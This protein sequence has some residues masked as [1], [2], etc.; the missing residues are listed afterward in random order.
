M[1]YLKIFTAILM[2][3]T[4][5]LGYCNKIKLTK[6]FSLL[7]GAIYIFLAI[8]TKDY[9]NLCWSS[10][11]LVGYLKLQFPYIYEDKWISVEDELPL[12][13]EDVLV[14][15]DYRKWG[16]DLKIHQARTHL[17]KEG[18]PQKYGG[19]NSLTGSGY[20]TGIYFSLPSIVAPEI[21]TH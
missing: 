18:F 16:R 12:P 21:V 9:W 2:Y 11:W 10:I 13:E 14:V 20:L 3:I 4:L 15:L 1:I 5:Y 7:I 8:F 19:P 17:A 6:V